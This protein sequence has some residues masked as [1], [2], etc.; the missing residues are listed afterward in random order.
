MPRAFGCLIVSVASAVVVAGCGAASRSAVDRTPDVAR[1]VVVRWSPFDA[2]GAVKRTFRIKTIPGG[3]GD[4]S[5]SEMIGGV[6]YRCGFGNYIIQTC[7]AAS[8]GPTDSAICPTAPW[9]RKALRLRVG[10]RFIFDAGVTY[11]G[12]PNVP[13][14]LELANGNRCLMIATGTGPMPTPEGRRIDRYICA[15]GINLAEPLRRGKRWAA[16]AARFTDHGGWKVIGYLPI[17][18]AYFAG[19]PPALSR[20]SR[21]AASAA[22]VG[23]KVAFARVR[24][25]LHI[26]HDDGGVHRVRLAFPGMAW[27]SVG[28]WVFYGSFGE[29]DVSVVLHRSSNGWSAL[30]PKDVCSKV[31]RAARAQLLAL[32]YC[33]RSA[34]R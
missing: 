23:T 2:S 9:D 25:E 14:A 34:G 19:L 24:R 13:W 1:T 30:A 32:S 21:L 3:C 29:R 12:A 10:P 15:H 28:V 33:R 27:A 17:K 18:R 11:A 22:A 20:Q 6:G 7:W 26:G 5:E 4:A 31:S 8:A 16:A